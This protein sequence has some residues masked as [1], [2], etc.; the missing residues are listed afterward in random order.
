MPVFLYGP[1]GSGKS[2]VGRLLAQALDL[3]FVDLDVEI[4]HTSGS[5]IAAMMNIQGEPAF[6]DME[7]DLLSKN[8][9]GKEKVIALGGGTLLRESNYE[10]VQTHGQV[11]FL[12]ADPSIMAER[13]RGDDNRR[14]LLAGDLETSLES[15]LEKRQAHYASFPLRVDA[16]QSPAQVVREIQRLLGRYRLRSMGSLYD[17]LVREGGL[18]ELGELLVSRVSGRSLMLVSDE[19]V[20]PLYAERALDSLRRAGFSAA[21]FVIPA[22]EEHKNI[23]TVMSL[24]QAC[25]KADL[26][27]SSTVVALGGGVVSDLAGFCAATFMRGCRWVAVPTTLLGMVDASLGGKTGFDLP[28]GKNLVGAFYP[29]SLVLADPQVLS[30]LPERQLR[31]GMAEVVKHG[32]IADPQLYALCASGWDVINNNLLEV[33]KRAMAVKVE[34]VEADPYEKGMRA[35]LNFGH[36]IGHA[37]ELASH[38]NLLH[39]EA[40]AIGMVIETEMAEGISLASKG[41]ADELA[42][43]LSVLGLPTVIP[44]NLSR[45]QLVNIVKVDKKKKDGKIRFALPVRIGEIKVNVEVEDWTKVLEEM[46]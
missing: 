10:L 2:T 31:A 1:S 36:T 14:P 30:T 23:E 46:E 38:F 8:V 18:D 7:S 24:W 13:L 4:E 41:L 25:L 27:R 3:E 29:P 43:T 11:V 32:V 39:G 19:N 20:A 34:L 35:A 22:G 40:V 12:E 26:D 45:N 5:S 15:L 33:V 44:C 42:H 6:R 17:V 37:L 9:D 16:S 28:E 21:Q